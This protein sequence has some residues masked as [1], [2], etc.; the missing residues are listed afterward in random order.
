MVDPDDDGARPSTWC[1][2]SRALAS[3]LA[4]LAELDDAFCS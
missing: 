1:S 3:E 2:S 4:E